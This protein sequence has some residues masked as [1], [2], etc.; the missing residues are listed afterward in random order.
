MGLFFQTFFA[1]HDFE[2]TIRFIYTWCRGRESNSHGLPH[3][4]LSLFFC[5]LCKWWARR[6]SNP[7]ALRHT[8]LSRTCIPI[9]PLAHH[10]RRRHLN[11]LPDYSVPIPPPR[12]QVYMK[13]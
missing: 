13:I 6:D 11:N 7:H 12:H 10:L 3:T 9:P 1:L 4:I 8:I 5:L 2:S